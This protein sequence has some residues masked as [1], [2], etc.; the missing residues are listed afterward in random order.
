M[1]DPVPDV[2]SEPAPVAPT[3]PVC[4][5]CGDTAVVHWQRRLTPAEIAVEQAKEQS[6]RD[7][8]VLLADPAL[9]PPEFG[10]L[11]DCTDWTHIVHGCLAH[12]ITRD[13]A[14]RIHQAACTAPNPAHTPGCDCTPEPLPPAPPEPPAAELPPGW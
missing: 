7:E 4:T 14:A 5:A 8:A 12:Y 3:G 11:P 13:A 6:R 10:P 2:Q 1:T 9:P